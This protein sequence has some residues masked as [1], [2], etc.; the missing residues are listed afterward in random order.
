MPRKN[1]NRDNNGPPDYITGRIQTKI[2]ALY[3][4]INA[5]H[6]LE[7][8]CLQSLEEE[9]RATVAELDD[10]MRWTLGADPTVE[11]RRLDLE[12]RLSRIRR[13]I[14]EQKVGVWRDIQALR[15][16]I[17]ELKELQDTVSEAERA[18]ENHRARRNGR[19]GNSV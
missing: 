5:R 12:N 2:E 17:R 6:E 1:S 16:E 4:E 14:R 19:R 15:K 18:A 7:Q 11:E 9:T 8:L 3:E 10:L 13:E